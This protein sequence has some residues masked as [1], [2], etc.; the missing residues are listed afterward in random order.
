M[1]ISSTRRQRLINFTTPKVADLVAV[2][3]VD[4]SKNLKSAASADNTAYGTAHPDS[5]NFPNHKLAY[6]KSANDDNGQFQLWYYVVDRANQD[7]YNWEFRSAGV[8]SVRYDTVV[9]AYVTLRSSFDEASPAPNAAMPISTSDPFAS[10]DG[11]VL[12]EKSQTRSGDETLDTLYVVEQRVYIKKVPLRN[13]NIDTEFPYDVETLGD[14]SDNDPVRGADADPPK[15]A[16]LEKETLYYKSENI[17]ATTVFRLPAEL[18]G[19]VDTLVDASVGSTTTTETAFRDPDLQYTTGDTNAGNTNFW[20]VDEFGVKRE[21]KQIS[22]NWYVLNERQVVPP[23]DA[24]TSGTNYPGQVLLSKHTTNETYAWPAVLDDTPQMENGNQNGIIGHTWQRK[25]GGG[26]TVTFPVYRREEY[27]GPCKTVREKIWRK[28]KW[29]MEGSGA[30]EETGGLTKLNPMHPLPI[31]FV[32]P[33]NKTSVKRT[34]HK[35]ITLRIHTGNNHPVYNFTAATF[36]YPATNYTDWPES[37]VVAD[38]QTFFRGGYLREKITVYPPAL[39][40]YTG[41]YH[42]DLY[43]PN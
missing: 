41:D 21:G 2:E 5:T 4:A 11:Y 6:I 25:N 10:A 13:I 29:L 3:V 19:G 36:V 23:V 9:R 42:D 40:E 28:K 26:D 38:T 33:L 14:P 12:F 15:G 35:A 24:A 39:E 8:A 34:L 43:G 31:H 22:D 18:T 37:L 1:A 7:D 30:G 20:G 27:Q 17:K 32:T 16:L